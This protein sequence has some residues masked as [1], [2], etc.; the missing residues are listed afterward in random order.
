MKKKIAMYGLIIALLSLIFVSCSTIKHGYESSSWR[1]DR[2]LGSL[3]IV[4][5]PQNNSTPVSVSD[6][7]E[8]TAKPALSPEVKAYDEKLQECF[9]GAKPNFKRAK[10]LFDQ[11][12]AEYSSQNG[13]DK[14]AAAYIGTLLL[15]AYDMEKKGQYLSENPEEFQQKTDK[16]EGLYPVS[17]EFLQQLYPWIDFRN[18]KTA[19]SAVNLL[20]KSAE[21][22]YCS[23]RRKLIDFHRQFPNYPY[24]Q[25]AEMLFFAK[26][27][28]ISF[29]DIKSEDV[30]DFAKKPDT[31][32]DAFPPF[33][34]SLMGIDVIYNIKD[35]PVYKSG[36]TPA[37]KLSLLSIRN[38]KHIKIKLYKV[39]PYELLKKGISLRNPEPLPG[40]KPI[41]EWTQKLPDIKIEHKPALCYNRDYSSPHYSLKKSKQEEVFIDPPP[42]PPSLSPDC[43]IKAPI[44]VTEPGYYIAAVETEYFNAYTPVIISDLDLLT[45]YDGDILLAY[46]DDNKKERNTVGTTVFTFVKDTK[47][48]SR[49]YNRKN[50]ICAVRTNGNPLGGYVIAEKNGHFAF[51]DFTPLPELKKQA[52]AFIYTDRPYYKAGQKVYIKAVMRLLDPAGG[53]FTKINMKKVELSVVDSKKNLLKKITLKPDSFGTVS[54]ELILP[55]DAGTGTYRIIAKYADSKQSGFF[56][57]RLAEYHIKVTFPQTT[58]I[59]G[60]NFYVKVH[61]KFNS[62]KP[63][64]GHKGTLVFK[65]NDNILK[66]IPFTLNEKGDVKIEEKADCSGWIYATAKIADNHGNIF[67]GKNY[68]K[69]EPSSQIVNISPYY[70]NYIDRNEPLKL[71]VTTKNAMSDK[72]VSADFIFY[73]IKTTNKN[74]KIITTRM[75]AGK[76]MRTDKN[77]NACYLFKTDKPGEYSATAITKDAKGRSSSSSTTITVREQLYSE[78][79][80]KPKKLHKGPEMEIAIEHRKY[81]PGSDAEILVKNSNSSGNLL[82]TMDTAKIAGFDILPAD[83][84]HKIILPED[85]RISSLKVSAYSFKKGK[86]ATTSENIKINGNL[87]TVTVSSNRKIYKPGEDAEITVICR[88]WDGTPADAELSLSIVDKAVLKTSRY[89]YIPEI[90]ELFKQIRYKIPVHTG[91]KV[92]YKTAFL[93]GIS[94]GSGGG[95]WS[96]KCTDGW[97][98]R[99]RR[100]FRETAVWIPNLRTDRDGISSKKIKLPDACTTWALRIVAVTKDGKAGEGKCEFKTVF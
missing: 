26:I 67:S 74:G 70:G 84:K 20:C 76:K 23:A 68:T 55:E 7:K 56:A 61:G 44:P 79:K 60:E 2:N 33:F 41:R 63:L 5:F 13:A 39:N 71:T 97:P 48:L 9:S 11:L 10:I 99:I 96:G 50:G 43:F 62:G 17:R 53:T 59:Q 73:I 46:S 1:R 42:P 24:N 54:T 51:S 4:R 36:E 37:V 12:L 80:V 21:E 65:K 93:N 100:N 64:K 15:L 98:S 77:G 92:H 58:T 78:Q 8:K 40:T 81:N 75:H 16:K 88:K 87:L 28:I 57:V 34:E 91:Y 85:S 32:E 18:V 19:K 3:P 35:M 72:P 66:T 38:K 25:Y 83:R 69:I 90:T 6:K 94:S 49:I 45:K 82:L 89:S 22:L 29:V 31:K 52:R 27:A 14:T 30:W 86:I 95:C 47:I